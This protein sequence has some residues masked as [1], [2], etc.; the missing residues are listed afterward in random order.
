MDTL[1][2]DELATILW[3]LDYRMDGVLHENS[4][5]L[6]ED[7]L[8]A[9]KKLYEQLN[10]VYLKIYDMWKSKDLEK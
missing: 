3:A 5:S 7:D 2:K 1:S 9:Q 6:D 10:A 8:V 4:L